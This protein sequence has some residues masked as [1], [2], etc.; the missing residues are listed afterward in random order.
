MLTDMIDSITN[1]LVDVGSWGLFIIAFMESSFFPIPPDVFQI[2]L[3]L[4][5]ME[6]A[7]WYGLVVTI[8]SV[9]GS[10]LGFYIGKWAGR[11]LLHRF[12]KEA[13]VNRVEELFQKYGA[14]AILIAAVTPIP[15]KVFTIAAGVFEIRLFSLLFW[16]AI[17]R[18]ARFMFSGVMIYYFGQA[19]IDFIKA[20]MDW[21]SILIALVLVV[22]YI[23]YIIVKRKR[24]VS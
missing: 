12:F 22:I 24:S 11:P 5:H 6:K 13:T 7:L 4:L 17:G 8:G 20:N 21:V 18:G 23:V 14:V 19:G 15:Y 2:A 1:W 9:L 10:I 3:S 16:S